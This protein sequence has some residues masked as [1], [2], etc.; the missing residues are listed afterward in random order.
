V[1]SDRDS[2]SGRAALSVG[3]GE[4]DIEKNFV[5]GDLK[6]EIGWQDGERLA[7]EKS[8]ACVCD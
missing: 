2:L 4:R 6:L 1:L 8:E 7:R 3:D 5:C